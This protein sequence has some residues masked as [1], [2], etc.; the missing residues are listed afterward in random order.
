MENNEN[1]GTVQTEQSLGA[2]IAKIAASMAVEVGI[3]VIFTAATGK[4]LTGVEMNRVEKVCT[5][6]ACGA[7]AGTAAKAC[8]GFISDKVDGIWNAAKKIG[9]LFKE[10]HENPDPTDKE[11]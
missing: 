5:S 11:E 10:L 8:D 7:L 4:V 6:L 3:G 2:S 1:V 9:A